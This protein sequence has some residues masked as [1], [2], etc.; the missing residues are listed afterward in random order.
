MHSSSIDPTVQVHL[1]TFHF[2]KVVADSSQ[3][4]C[5]AWLCGAQ[6]VVVGDAHIVHRVKEP[7]RLQLLKKQLVQAL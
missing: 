3:A 1:C 5:D 7:F 6:P 2:Y 4:I